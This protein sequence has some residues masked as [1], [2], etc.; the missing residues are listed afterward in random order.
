M[1]AVG[2]VAAAGEEQ[3]YGSGEPFERTGGGTG[4][5]WRRERSS[6]FGFRD[7][8]GAHGLRNI[9]VGSIAERMEGERELVANLVVDAAGDADAAG[10]GG[11]LEARGD[12]DAVA[13]K[14]LVLHHNVAEI[15]ADAKADLARGRQLVIEGAQGGLNI[16]GAADGFDGAGKFGEDG[17]TGGVE[18]AAAMQDD[19][20]F[21]NL[22]VTAKGAE[23]LLFVLAHQAAEF[24]D[25]GGEDG[26]Q[27]AF[28]ELRRRVVGIIGNV[29]IVG[30]GALRSYSPRMIAPE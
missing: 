6:L 24:G 29:G 10:L 15:D 27:L 26:G 7:R 21:E 8:K 16:G 18:D 12:I 13:E 4:R 25:V 3:D 23:G 11:G 17:V 30:H 19:Q 9:F 2:P 14:V 20:G 5:L 22:L 1:C 28:E